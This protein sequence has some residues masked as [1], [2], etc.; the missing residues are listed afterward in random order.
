VLEEDA[1]YR[2]GELNS[3]V[4]PDANKAPFSKRFYEKVAAGKV[5]LSK[6]TL[7][8]FTSL[9]TALAAREI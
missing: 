2:S 3:A 7:G 4:I 9:L 6:E 5:K 8:N 1:A